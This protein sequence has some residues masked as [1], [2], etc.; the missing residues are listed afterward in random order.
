MIN[1]T[2]N[3]AIFILSSFVCLAV[4]AK[5]I[6]NLQTF[7]NKNQYSIIGDTKYRVTKNNKLVKAKNQNVSKN[8]I[9]IMNGKIYGLNSKKGT[10]APLT[11]YT[12]TASFITYHVVQG[13]MIGNTGYVVGTRFG[14]RW[15]LGP[16][17]N[18]MYNARGYTVQSDGTL[19]YNPNLMY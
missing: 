8:G 5:P 12:G 18:V 15:I 14:K 3:S 13:V 16:G 10:Y 9:V 11:T 1:F 2:K 6:Q 4:N 7:G 17:T 19:K